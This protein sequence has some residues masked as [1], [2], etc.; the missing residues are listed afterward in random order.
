MKIIRKYPPADAR[1]KKLLVAMAGGTIS[2]EARDFAHETGFFVLEL[3][4]DTVDLIPPPEGFYPM[5]W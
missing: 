2:P 1:G 3:R 4:G 5:E